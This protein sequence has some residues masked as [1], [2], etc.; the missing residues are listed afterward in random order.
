MQ[1]NVR[2]RLGGPVVGTVPVTF[3]EFDARGTV[4]ALPDLDKFTDPEMT[5]VHP[6]LSRLLDS[7]KLDY[8][9]RSAVVDEIA[10]RRTLR[11]D[12]QAIQEVRTN[13]S[14]KGV[15]RAAVMKNGFVL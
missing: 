8:S 9:R 15:V 13:P 2:V 12:A 6:D 10:R 1:L 7:L 14:D 4:D 3:P 11:V 5:G